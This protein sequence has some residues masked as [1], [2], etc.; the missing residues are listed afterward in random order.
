VP[1]DPPPLRNL[2]L[3]GTM[4]LA[5]GPSG[6]VA[7]GEDTGK[8]G[9]AVL[10]APH[11]AWLET[12]RLP[13]SCVVG[14]DYA[15]RIAAAAIAAAREHLRVLSM[16]TTVLPH[17]M[18]GCDGD[19]EATAATSTEASAGEDA[20]GESAL[21]ALEL[22]RGLIAL[23]LSGHRTLGNV[24]VRAVAAR[25]PHLAELALGATD[26]TGALLSDLGG[27]LLPRLHAVSFALC[28]RLTAREVEALRVRLP[29][30]RVEWDEDAALSA[31]EA[32]DEI[33]DEE[34]P[35]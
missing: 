14:V 29:K 3:A 32:E 24:A 33:Y 28:H 4:L 7:E 2:D 20:L 27:G 17:H 6:D 19:A 15:G 26:V 30:V 35:T 13:K 11:L 9:P 12:L 10:A 1:L 25:C 22:P 34:Y 31:T 23:D 5:E 21:A 16:A 18:L 8:D